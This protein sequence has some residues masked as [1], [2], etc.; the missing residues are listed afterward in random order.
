VK[1][2]AMATIES[3]IEEIDHLRPVSDVA[4]KVMSI[5]DDPDSG[6]S[7]LVDIIRYEPALTQCAQIG[8]LG[9]FWIARQD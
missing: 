3:L 4:G 5:L 2:P 1:K 9:L 6:S 7:D 8:Q